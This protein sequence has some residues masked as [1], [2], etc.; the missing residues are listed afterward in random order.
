MFIKFSNS[1]VEDTKEYWFWRTVTNKLVM[2]SPFCRSDLIDK[3]LY[4]RYE[5][6]MEEFNHTGPLKLRSVTC[7]DITEKFLRLKYASMP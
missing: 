2:D 7:P 5:L 4:D 3:Y 1:E 6:V